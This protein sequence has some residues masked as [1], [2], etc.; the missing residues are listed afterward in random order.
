VGEEGFGH[1]QV[2]NR[3][4]EL[5]ER[6]HDLLP[7]LD[8][9]RVA[10]HDAHD[11]LAVQFSGHERKW[12]RLPVDYD[13]HEL[14]RCLRYPLAVETQDVRRIFHRPEDRSSEHGRTHRVEAELELGD[15]AEVAASSPHPPEEVRVLRRARLDEFTLGS[16]QIHG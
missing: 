16:D 6:L 12:W 5:L 10:A 3:R 8:R 14:I 2:E 7:L 15:N 11:Q 13:R 4:S 9:S 1:A